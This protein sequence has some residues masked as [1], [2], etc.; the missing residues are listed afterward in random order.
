M[1]SAVY[2]SVNKTGMLYIDGKLKASGVAIYS[3]F[4]AANITISESSGSCPSGNMPGAVDE[5]KIFN[6]PLTAPE[7]LSE[8]YST[9]V[10]LVAFFPFNGNA[11][12]ASGNQNHGTVHNS[13]LANDRFGITDKAF[14]FE[15]TDSYIQGTNPGNNLPAGNS[16]RTISAWIKEYSFH[17]WGNNIFHYG[18]DQAAPTNFHLYTTDVIRVGNGYD[19]G[20]VAGSTSIVDATWHFVAG[21]YEGGSEHVAKVYVDGKLNN[22]GNLSSEPNTIL[23]S[24]WKIGRFMT[25]SNNFDGKIDD[26]R[27]FSSA[28]TD[29]EIENLYLSETTAPQL[30]KPE[31]ISVVSGLT[32]L[33]EWSNINPDPEYTFE[34]SAEPGFAQTLY[35]SKTSQ[36][37]VQLPEGLIE[38]NV[39]YFWRVR[40]S[41]NGE[42]GPWSDTRSFSSVNTGIADLRPNQ[43]KLT[44][45]PNP[46]DNSGRIT[47]CIPS[48]K[49]GLVMVSVEVI[50]ATGKSVRKLVDKKQN[51]GAYD[52]ELNTKMLP[53]G[54]YYIK[55]LTE[56][57]TVT[58]KMVVVH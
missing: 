47:Y 33:M 3:N 1:V 11:D 21:V 23:G 13:V 9:Q 27:I 36:P 7:I 42:T 56:N 12:D 19:F 15:G 32:P 38:E 2:D 24:N 52:L 30:L 6:R 17:P 49:T 43:A 37:H 4:N 53:D 5:V 55:L 35:Q 45:T 58:N 29:Q 22:T 18:T 57:G 34:L 40:A 16:P 26:L 14:L 54:V 8:F 28:L 25:G 48:S 50:N 20:V 41:L 39:T 46:A 10:G 51:P 31:D 44:I